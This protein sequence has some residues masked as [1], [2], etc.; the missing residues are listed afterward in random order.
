MGTLRLAGHFDVNVWRKIRSSDGLEF[1]VMLLPRTP[2]LDVWFFEI[3]CLGQGANLEITGR[4]ILEY[5]VVDP[6][7]YVFGRLKLE[8]AE[9]Y[10]KAEKIAEQAALEEQEAEQRKSLHQRTE[11]L[12]ARFATENIYAANPVF[13]RMVAEEREREIKRREWTVYP[14]IGYVDVY[15]G[16][17]FGDPKTVNDIKFHVINFPADMAVYDEVSYDDG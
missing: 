16:P 9:L 3:H 5:G 8:A 13:E 6:L 4:E 17:R 7:N 14:I 2:N 1:E 15:K 11:E 10:A 12:M